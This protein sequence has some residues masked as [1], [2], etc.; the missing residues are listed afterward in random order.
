M[1]LRT[2]GRNGPK[3]SVVGYG[4]WE[5]GDA[6]WGAAGD[7]HDALAAMH[8]AV[9]AGCT[10]IDTAEAYGDGRSEEL[11]GRLI[12][13]RGREDVMV[14]TKVA[15]FVSGARPQEVRRAIIGSL[16]RLG[17][18]HVDLFQIHWPHDD[19]PVEET[20]GAMAELQ[21]EGLARAIGV[22]NFDRSLIERCLAVRHV[23]SVQNQLSLLHPQ[24][25]AELIPWLGEQG[26]GYLA[27][28]P[29]AFGLLT[30]AFTTE[31]TFDD[32]DW[33]SGTRWQLGYYEEL[34][35]PGRFEA[36][37]ER[38]E[39]LRPIAERAGVSVATLALRA[40]LEV[41]FVSG[42]I[43]GSRRPTHV[44]ANA[45]AGEIVLDHATLAAVRDAV[46]VRS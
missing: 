7:E 44:R 4:A 22:S 9:D 2:L 43:A 34:F 45:A 10:W 15:H 6:M 3:I 12:A 19:V 29:L 26:V 21:D 11:V 25:A 37:L 32:G 28:G 16:E 36:N 24:D 13:E 14:F 23:D 46:R 40:V 30:G 5:A 42:V 41:P 39:E 8:A 31:T 1:E 27:Y 17:T 33:R 38:V 35:A 20:W 18:D